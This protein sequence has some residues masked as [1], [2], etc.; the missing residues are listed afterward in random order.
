M[1]RAA[2]VFTPAQPKNHPMNRI[3]FAALIVASFALSACSS[4]SADTGPDRNGDTSVTD[5]GAGD[6]TGE[7]DAADDVAAN[8]DETPDTATQDAAPTDT[9]NPD[10]IE[11][12]AQPDTAPDTVT[13]VAPD[14]APD[15]IEDTAV[16][17]TPEDTGAA[18]ACTNASD[19]AILAASADLEDK[20]GTCAFECISGG[21]V[22]GTACIEREVG[23]SNGCS[24]CFGETIA[25]TVA[26]CALQC[27]SPSSPNC[28]SCRETNCTPAFTECSGITPP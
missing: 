20:I 27:I 15:V 13:D 21:A 4:E 11:A 1:V 7:A 19:T 24:T 25:C 17:T 5:T 12:D 6:T 22:C 18:G 10:V 28:A 2:L 3:S 23:L 9:G 8:T 16:D 26:S 14:V